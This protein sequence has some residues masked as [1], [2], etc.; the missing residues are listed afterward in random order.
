MGAKFEGRSACPYYDEVYGCLA[1]YIAK[2][3]YDEDEDHES[4]VTKWDQNNL[5]LDFLSVWF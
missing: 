5:R 3:P 1:C 4:E 2:C